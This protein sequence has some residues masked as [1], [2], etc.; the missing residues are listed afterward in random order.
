[1]MR[2]VLATNNVGKLRELETLLQPLDFVVL[3][4][5]QF[6]SEAVIE[7]GDSFVANALL[8]ARHAA[9]VSGLP[10]LA[11]DS[12]IEVDALNGAP[13]IYSARYAGAQATDTDN[14]YK[15]LDAMQAV[16]DA[17]R[18]ARYRCALV[19]VRHADDVAPVICEASWEGRIARAASGNGGFGYDPIFWLP[20][21][22]CSA[23][24][25]DP[26]IKNK[27]S[28]RGQALQLLWRALAVK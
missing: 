22:G 18:S 26:E 6:T 20:E 3:P 8:K 2:V 10:A 11:D 27:L 28:H 12:G 19:Y 17:E 15:L 4:K 21:Q 7:S 5:A 13:G 16:A 25:L 9:Y 1:M 24:E 23:A 14:L